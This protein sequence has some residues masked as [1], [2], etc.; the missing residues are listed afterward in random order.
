[1]RPI[2]RLDRHVLREVLTP[3]L[4]AFVI[5]TVLILLQGLI[6][7]MEQV[8]VHGVAPRDALYML[9]I[10]VPSVVVLTIPMSYLF[11]VLLGVGRLTADNEL[12][13]LES[14][15]ISSNRLLRPILA[16][17]L[18]LALFSGYLYVTVIPESNRRLSTIKRA[19][20]ASG[21]AIGRIEARVF[22]DEFPNTLL[23]VDEVD[24]QSGQWRKVM[25][26]RSLNSDEEQ[27]TLARRGRI[28]EAAD[29]ATATE[30]ETSPSPG[31]RPA[32]P[33]I[34]L[35]DMVTYTI[36]RDEPEKNSSSRV[37][38]HAFKP[39]ESG[40]SGARVRYRLALRERNTPDLAHFLR[41]GRFLD[42][43]VDA[44]PPPSRLETERRL[45]SVELH[46]RFAIPVA[47][48]T[49]AFLALPLG[50]GARAGG[51]GRGFLLSIGVVLVYYVLN[52]YGE[53][54]VVEKGFPAWFGIWMP[55][56]L[57]TVG[58][59]LLYLRGTHRLG[60]RQPAEG[61]IARV[62]RRLRTLREERRRAQAGGGGFDQAYTGSIPV[63]VQRRR[64]SAWAF[65]SMLDRYA[66]NRMMVP[67]LLMLGSTLSLFLIADLTDRVDDI[68][69]HEVPLEVVLSYYWSIVPQT[70]VDTI[71]IA[72]L[73]SVLTVLTIMGRQREITA[74]K[75]AGVSI[76][77][78]QVPLVII[79]MA[80]AGSMWLLSEKVVPES[81]R[82][83]WRLMERIKGHQ[84]PRMIATNR[85][86]LLSRDGR[87]YYNF[88]SYDLETSTL[89]RFS[90]IE[91]D[92]QMRLR[93]IVSAPRVRWVE[94]GWIADSGWIRRFDPTSGVEDF[95][96]LT[97]PTELPITESPKYFGQER[98]KPSEMTQAEL[99][100]YIRE[101]EESGYL[102]TKLRVRWHQKVVVP[103]SALVLVLMALP[104]ALAS[105]GR[106]KSTMQGVAMAVGLG[107]AYLVTVGLFGKLGEAE[108][109]PPVVSAWAP[110]V[111]S[112]LFAANRMTTVKT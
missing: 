19:F 93:S 29:A 43:E 23:Y 73:V 79:A 21:A 107:L 109:L 13:A 52:T 48:I 39:M 17:G 100:V 24:T 72:L 69:E 34:V 76:F 37:Q 2:T 71:P 44:R 66:V 105:E 11:G 25:I 64:Y 5:Y 103:L 26:H 99:G 10:G 81:N 9:W 47:C 112:V 106:R 4:L 59:A 28:V 56:M 54:L 110:V 38:S 45:A 104:L 16:A 14:S 83:A 65:P 91:V 20:F 97:R 41:E 32:E 74:L 46:R 86:W 33:W 92:Q 95:R 51:R 57:T 12:M 40:N 77:R 55:N 36:N 108:L 98:R 111:L 53:V 82:E 78:L 58:A 68:I 15:G 1:V 60:E 50:I 27:L 90:A 88:L 42:D 85:T 80:G 49:F 67:L 22:Y 70:L 3:S 18:L 8:V 75:A 96:R 31:T 89:V 101:L 6:G 61:L 30:T 63:N 102:D 62:V 35:E 7:L 94:G 87:T 84:S